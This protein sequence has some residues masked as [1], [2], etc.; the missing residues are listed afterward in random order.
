MALT[1]QLFG[2]DDHGDEDHGD[3]DGVDDDYA[4]DLED[5]D[6]D[7]NDQDDAEEVD[8]GDR[9][10]HGCAVRA[11]VGGGQGHQG[12]DGEDQSSHVLKNQERKNDGN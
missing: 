10:D 2:D 12:G 6:D 3:N 7:G 11:R 4:E 1:W 5:Y 9:A 8:D